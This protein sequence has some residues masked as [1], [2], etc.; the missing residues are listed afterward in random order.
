MAEAFKDNP[1]NCCFAVFH[2]CSPPKNKSELC[3]CVCVFSFENVPRT[4][5]LSRLYTLG[6]DVRGYAYESSSRTILFFFIYICVWSLNRKWKR[7]I[8][9]F[10]TLPPLL[11]SRAT[12]SGCNRR[13]NHI[14]AKHLSL[15]PRAHCNPPSSCPPLPLSHTHTHTLPSP[16]C[17]Y[18]KAPRSVLPGV[19]SV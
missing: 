19:L 15:F 13:A 4:N 14:K 2:C 17:T 16:A 3:V 18:I 8:G 9:Y 10:D 11:V 1:A 12:M 7:S 6:L 5:F